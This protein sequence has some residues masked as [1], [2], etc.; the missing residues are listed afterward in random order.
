MAEGRRRDGWETR[1]RRRAAGL[2]AGVEGAEAQRTARRASELRCLAPLPPSI[3][4]DSGAQGSCLAPTSPPLWLTRAASC[5]SSGMFQPIKAVLP[6]SSPGIAVFP[7]VSVS[8]LLLHLLLGFAPSPHHLSSVVISPAL[9]SLVQS[10]LQP[11]CWTCLATTCPWR[12]I[13]A[14]GRADAST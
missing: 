10:C 2:G 12:Q 7:H 9:V 13:T 14:Q 6:H 4:S 5:L 8:S 11:Q 3:L 1:A